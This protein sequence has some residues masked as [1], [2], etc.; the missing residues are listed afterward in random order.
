LASLAICCGYNSNK[1]VIIVA[2]SE[3]MDILIRTISKQDLHYADGYSWPSETPLVLPNVGDEV[4]F[5]R[6]GSRNVVRRSFCYD[7]RNQPNNSV[8]H[9]IINIVCE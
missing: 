8:T 9:L 1:Q 2:S 4:E 5:S 6:F 7:T 3:S